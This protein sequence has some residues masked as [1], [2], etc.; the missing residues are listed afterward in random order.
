LNFKLYHNLYFDLDRTLW[1]YETNAS[2]ALHE[3][4]QEFEL[5]PIFGQ[6]DNFRNAFIKYND[7]LWRQYEKG[8]LK[9]E[10]LRVR[11]FELAL[12][13]YKMKDKKLSI[14]LNDSF[15]NISPR[16][17]GL[18]PGANEALDYLKSKSYR[19]YILTNGF[20]K[21][22]EIKMESAGLNPYFEKMFT[23]EN[24]KSH[25]PKRAIFE[26]A[27]KSVNAKK[28]ESLMIG[29]DLEVDIIGARNFGMDQVYFNPAKTTHKEMITYEISNLAELK[30]LL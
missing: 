9:K 25:K 28:S 5:Q 24:T 17:P 16:K 20:T 14:K 7:A 23:T 27:L 11:R 8:T 26:H 1:D 3:I 21:I 4:F 6:F 13:D 18:M 19:M 29:D 2:E 22:Q 10:T 12:L 30:N 15:L